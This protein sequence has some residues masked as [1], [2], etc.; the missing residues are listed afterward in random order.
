MPR[1]SVVA[2]ALCLSLLFLKFFF[3]IS[4]QARV[5]LTTKRFQY[6]EDAKAWNGE[7]VE[8]EAD[9]VVRAQ[10]VLRNDSESQ[11][12]FLAAAGL[13]T[14]LGIWPTGAWLYFG[15]YALSR[16][17]HAVCLLRPKQPLRNVAFGTGMLCLLALLVHIG[18]HLWSSVG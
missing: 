13:Y 9:S 10:R 17:L 16:W 4:V 1:D 15:V 6:A 12:F 7:L 2:Y 3:T 5:R 11:P 18:V 8:A 14:A